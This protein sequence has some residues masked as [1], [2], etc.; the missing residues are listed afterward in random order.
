MWRRRALFVTACE[1]AISWMASLPS[2][3]WDRDA[4]DWPHRQVSDFI[5]C[6]GLRWHVQRMGEGP[7]CLLLHGT[8]ASTHSFAGLMPALAGHF[9][10][11]AVDLPGHGFTSRPKELSG[12]SMSGMAVALRALLTRLGIEPQWII[13]HSAGA[14]IACHMTLAGLVQPSGLVSING[15]LLPLSG[16]KHPAVTPLLRK[17]ASSDWLAGWFADRLRKPAAVERLLAQTGSQLDPQGLEWYAR[18]ARTASHAGAAMA[19]MAVW[20]PR[21][22]ERGLPSLEVPL[23]LLVGAEDRMI[24]PGEA[25]KVRRLVKDSTLVQ[26]SG[27]GHLAHEEAPQRVAD[28]ILKFAQHPG[29]GVPSGAVTG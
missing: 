27:L 11:I 25:A 26:L 19:M 3:D 28:E 5:E 23:L 4:T 15:A 29:L 6:D 8:G 24:L 17:V 20:D 2:L 13:G 9:S 1:R 16:F 21:P 22:L 12:L 10:L 7:P 14:A 18:L